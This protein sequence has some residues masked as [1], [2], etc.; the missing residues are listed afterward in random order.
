MSATKKQL[1][2]I[3]E[4]L[5]DLGL[6]GNSLLHFSPR[7]KKH[8]DIIDEKSEEIFRLLVIEE[9]KMSF[10]P[11]PEA[12]HSDD[13]DLIE[14]TLPT[15]KEYLNEEKG[16]GRFTDLQ[17]QSRISPKDLD[18]RLLRIENE[19]KTIYQERGIDVL[20]LALG[21]LRWFED[22]NSS[23]ERLAPLMLVPVQLNRT[24]AGKGFKLSYTG[25]DLS[26]NE[27]LYAKIKN[28]FNIELPRSIADSQ[29][30][31]VL[32]EYFNAIND[33]VKGLN[34][35]EVLENKIALGLF[36]FG[37]FQ[38][39]KDLDPLVWPENE[40]PFD[41]GI[42][43]ALFEDGFEVENEN[44]AIDS[45][46]SNQIL[47]P[48]KLNLV[49]DADSTQTEAIL[50]VMHGQSI[51][52]QGPPG[53]GK[54][55]TITNLI[56]EAISRDKKVLFVAQKLTAL[57]V[58]KNRLDQTHIGHS[59][60]ELHSHKSRPREVLDSIQ[61]T[62]FEEKPEIPE[63]NTERES[64]KRV[65]SYLDQYANLLKQTIGE[66]NFIFGK[67]LGHYVLLKK[68]LADFSASDSV[69]FDFFRK[70][71]QEDW[72]SF[73]LDLSLLF[74]K[75]SEEGPLKSNP[76]Y[77]A[78]IREVT[79]EFAQTMSNS[80]HEMLDLLRKRS[81]N[82]EEV[83]ELFNLANP[84]KE[85]DFFKVLNSL[86]CISASKAVK[87]IDLE[88]KVL[89]DNSFLKE[90]IKLISEL[91]VFESKSLQVFEKEALVSG[92][93]K[94]FLLL[95]KT[96]ELYGGKWYS[97]LNSKF[98]Q[99][100]GSYNLLLNEQ[101]KFEVNDSINSLNDLIGYLRNKS[102]I[103][104]IEE[105]LKKLFGSEWK[106]D[107]S[108]WKSCQEALEFAL[109]TN[110]SLK[111]GV[112]DEKMWTIISASFAQ[113]DKSLSYF[114]ELN[115]LNQL[116]I[117]KWEGIDQVLNNQ[118]GK[119]P[120]D[121]SE[122]YRLF[123]NR[124]DSPNG[125]FYLSQLNRLLAR[126][127]KYQA[128]HL[129]SLVYTYEGQYSDLHDYIRFS[130]WQIL[131]NDFYNQNEL[132]RNFDRTIHE[133]FVKDFIELD[134]NT[135]IHAQEFLVDH[136]H[137]KLPSPSAP[138]EMSLLRREMAK[139]RRILP[140]RRLLEKA[141]V[142]IQKIKPVFMMSPMSVAT[143][144]PPGKIEFDMVI[145]DE[146]SQVPIPDSIGAML[147]AKQ[148]IVVGDSK[149]MPPSS[150][151]GKSI[152]VSDEELE[153]DFTAEIE[154][155]LDL[156]SA[157]GASET[158]LKWHYRSKHE[159]LIYTSNKEFYESRL[160]VFPSSG[161]FNEATG[162]R[163]IHTSESFYDRSVSRTNK[164]EAKLVAD[165]VKEHV[166]KHPDLSLG[167]V[168][169]SMAQKEA[170]LLEVEF[171][172]RSNP[173]LEDFFNQE[174]FDE[175]FFVKNL[176]N[177]QGDERDVI[178]ISIGYG[179]TES[180]KL[181]KN[182]GPINQMGGERRLNVLMSR[183]KQ[184]MIVFSN[185]KSEELLTDASS[186][187]GLKV[188]KSFLKYAETGK[189]D[190]PV[191]SGKEA[192]SIFEI[193]VA[194][195]ITELGYSVE[196]QVG[197]QGFYIDMAIR[198]PLKEGAY[199]LAVECDGATY[200]SSANARDRD[201]LRQSILESVGWKFHRIWSTDWFRDEKSE[202]ERI[203][204]RIEE[205]LNSNG[206]E[207]KTPKRDAKPDIIRVE[208]EFEEKTHHEY[209][210]ANL[211]NSYSWADY[212]SFEEIPKQQLQEAISKVV[213]I[214]GPLHKQLLINR[215]LEPAYLT[216]AG[217]KI[218]NKVDSVLAFMA[219]T[220]SI[221]LEHDCLF[222]ENQ[223]VLVRDRS[224]LDTAERKFE[225]VPPTEIKKCLHEVTQD[226][227]SIEVPELFKEVCSRFGFGRTTESMKS[228]L[229]RYLKEVIES[230]LLKLEENKISLT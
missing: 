218:K 200:H 28:D 65:K 148:V 34:R 158:M 208:R 166:E 151:F 124:S 20:F 131:L 167:V 147:R 46:L 105:K 115:E 89:L 133:R 37:K 143:F 51:V 93:V 154:S 210:V 11:A 1:E 56:A 196:P 183:A 26:E 77:G 117:E 82:L 66:T 184:Q 25:L 55:Q 33:A 61:A 47:F 132:I 225:L 9:K 201:R 97:F 194:K 209:T 202:V 221:I 206:T 69:S 96:F 146:A 57:E 94:E 187:F 2:N 118:S 227:Y 6:R 226:A 72:N 197:S 44:T 135:F 214:E 198:H 168:A 80:N 52:V 22:N 169:F 173:S 137:N 30:E 21:F 190:I 175:P 159:S 181:N 134:Q 163:F 35:F 145:F 85:N 40:K 102:E 67:A 109:E 121:L 13:S 3:R 182:F 113:R 219:S 27:T 23:K 63:R 153:E 103:L 126:F 224:K 70:F 76:Y 10:L 129:I 110:K 179:K 186:P 165:Y 172:R 16:E 4:K 73:E 171:M 60:L 193:E 195:R 119:R 71:S 107:K 54:S 217:R 99:A 207:N 130:F 58:V 188:L 125:L 87:G 123:K 120:D 101:K 139:K 155:V 203:R 136:I 12:F 68:S 216:R 160:F 36:S 223:E 98:R 199:L 178:L 192:D 205:V 215:L 86:K 177:V 17:L 104:E 43:K 142:I 220:K 24:A 19:A 211:M 7:G 149:Q 59:V 39:Y 164:I 53:T 152:E 128:E 64:L 189:G 150:F 116:I 83:K 14:F 122:Q 156:F 49:K 176:E 88:C 114:E 222:V 15:L 31:L 41:Q 174:G 75:L 5:L 91:R 48:E 180:G 78:E 29:A 62:L 140:V 162:L 106:G 204:L 111:E 157:Q 230:G 161:L 108:D 138:G 8:I 191:E 185:F 127:E 38:M 228:E 95:R 92:D 141:G 32:T 212:I 74:E 84:E 229:D 100:K 45:D 170:I 79:Q 81:K 50:K 213:M 42:L 144:L 90:S 18:V 112:L